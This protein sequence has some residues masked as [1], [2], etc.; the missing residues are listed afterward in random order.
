[1]EIIATVSRCW[2]ALEWG[3]II[4]WLQD[5]DSH[6]WIV[7]AE[8]GARGYKHWQMRFQWRKPEQLPE[9]Q[10]IAWLRMEFIKILPSLKRSIHI[11]I[12]T[13][14]D[15]W[16][17]ESKEGRYIASWD[18]FDTLKLRFGKPKDRQKGVLQAL[19]ATN[20]RQVVV[21]YD[22]EGNAGKSWYVSY[23]VETGQ[24]YFT[25]SYLTSVKDVV[26]AV[27]SQAKEDRKHGWRPRPY[28][29]IDIPRSWKWSTE[30][31]TGIEALKDGLIM[32]PRYQA[33]RVNIRG[34]KVLICTNTMPKLDKLSA[35]RWII[36]EE[37]VYLDCY[38]QTAMRELA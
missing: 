26:Q 38:G 27:A 35:D 29:V 15:A 1:M 37:P 3:A 34:T 6:K 14:S 5:Q 28:L 36:V 33:E 25:P 21:W 9:G 18:S 13:A 11:E 24:A 17:Y 31:Y 22:K 16:A 7:A 4:R 2:T 23:L 8:T 30:L 10:E 12:A 19:Q 20:D 32:D